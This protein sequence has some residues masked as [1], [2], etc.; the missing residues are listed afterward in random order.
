[1]VVSF[2]LGSILD[3]FMKKCEERNLEVDEKFAYNYLHLLARDSR[4]GLPMRKL[5]SC[6]IA[7]FIE[8]A[9]RILENPLDPT[10]CTFKMVY[11]V[12]NCKE[13][14][15]EFLTEKYEKEFEQ[16]LQFFLHDI[17]QYPEN[18]NKKQIEELFHKMIIFTIINFTMGDPKDSVLLRNGKQALSSVIGA[19]DLKT[20]IHK[21]RY[22][23]VAYLKRLS[24]TVCGIM[25][26]TALGP[27]NNHEGIRDL[28]GDLEMAKNNT[29]KSLKEA[30]ADVMKLSE[31]S[32]DGISKMIQLDSEKRTI[33]CT[34][35]MEKLRLLNKYT[36]LFEVYTKFLKQVIEKFEKC[37]VQIKFNIE[38][39]TCVINRIIEL[40]KFRTAINREVI[41]PHFNYL[42]KLWNNLNFNLNVLVEIN[43]IKDIMDEY[44]SESIRKNFLEIL[45]TSVKKS[46]LTK[47]PLVYTFKE[48]LKEIE[49]RELKTNFMA[50]PSIIEKHCSLTIA[51]T[52]GVL[53]PGTINKQICDNMKIKFGFSNL[54]LSKFAQRHFEEFILKLN[55]TIFTSIDLTLLYNLMDIIL[56]R[57]HEND[58]KDDPKFKNIDTQTEMVIVNDLIPANKND[59]TFNK[60]DL[61]RET[62]HLAN[63]KKSQTHS[64]QTSISYGQRDSTTQTYRPKDN[65]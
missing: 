23:R 48:N 57:D 31:M 39:F 17:L 52:Q 16:K 19:D 9:L 10:G 60:W 8:G 65:P 63:I 21:K 12:N 59:S 26:Y 50:I 58:V 24:E 7:Y 62:I 20:Y 18:S 41:F 53:L 51:L 6:D 28:I 11:S 2:L 5:T 61:H 25:L 56:K 46:M 34:W 43:R 22:N 14:E 33:S 45:K 44:N 55:N 32:V 54:G 13:L 37:E 30:E 42:S 15:N 29:K 49:R 64:T 40:L 1:M 36:V 27:S 4:D 38:K 3:E 35:P 47:S